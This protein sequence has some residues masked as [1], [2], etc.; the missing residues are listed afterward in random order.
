MFTPTRDFRQIDR[1]PWR[2]PTILEW[3]RNLTHGEVTTPDK[4]KTWW[5]EEATD[6]IRTKL[7]SAARGVYAQSAH[8][9]NQHPR[10]E[11]KLPR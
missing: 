4:A 10:P 8:M 7:R 11:I 6:E 5:N 2:N 1:A 3:I 9:L